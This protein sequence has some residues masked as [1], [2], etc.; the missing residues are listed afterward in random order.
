MSAWIW[1]LVAAGFAV[2]EVA[3]TAFFALF[4]ALGALCAAV[5]AGVGG[6]LVAQSTVF[7]ATAV[8]GVVVARRPLLR[9]VN[10]RNRRVLRSGFAGLVGEQGTVVARVEGSHTPGAVHVRGEDWPAITFDPVAY[11][12]GQ[13]VQVVDTDRTRLV[14]T[15]P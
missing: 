5:A 12:P 1:L 14:V 9:W 3:S 15:A 10:P 13:T 2:A 7:A 8:A 4:A 11:E 6:G